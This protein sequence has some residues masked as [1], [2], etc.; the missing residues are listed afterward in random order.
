MRV[1]SRY[2]HEISKTVHSLDQHYTY[3]VMYGL[4]NNGLYE[5]PHQNIV[6][7]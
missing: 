5:N 2:Q 7:R 3:F 1:L 4:N 6:Y